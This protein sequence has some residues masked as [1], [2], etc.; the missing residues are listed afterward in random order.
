MTKELDF[1][2]AWLARFSG[3]LDEVAGEGIRRKVMQGSQALSVESSD[4]EIL[5][6]TKQA[7]ERLEAF[8]EEDKRKAIMTGCAC[9]H[10]KS[11]LRD[12]KEAY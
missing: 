8:V 11:A 1:E 4:R 2:R 9:R 7:M 10:S 3:C 6:W 12:V 5:D